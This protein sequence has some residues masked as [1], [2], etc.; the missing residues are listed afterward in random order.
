MNNFTPYNYCYLQYMTSTCVYVHS[1]L[2]T[3]IHVI[4]MLITVSVHVNVHICTPT[5]NAPTVHVH[6]YITCLIVF[7]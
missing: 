3:F 1:I 2:L 5:V 4:N 6:V 7:I